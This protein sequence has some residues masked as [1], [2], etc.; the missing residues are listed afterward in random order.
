M[1]IKA[2]A[3]ENKEAAIGGLVV[4]AAAACGAF[5]WRRHKNKKT[6]AAEA[7]A[8]QEVISNLKKA[9]AAEAAMDAVKE[10]SAQPE[11]E[12]VTASAEEPAVHSEEP[13]EEVAVVQA[14]I[15]TACDPLGWKAAVSYP[16]I[17]I[18]TPAIPSP[19]D[20]RFTRRGFTSWVNSAGCV[21]VVHITKANTSVVWRDPDGNFYG[22]TTIKN[23]WETS[24]LTTQE[25]EY[26]LKGR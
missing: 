10:P 17:V 5:M 6:A 2:I 20:L 18:Y 25:V 7:G 24:E 3:V 21:G 11:E 12:E 16:E 26:F 22:K 1:D 9:V 15:R 13:V 4:V 14:T 23:R 8:Y 19:G